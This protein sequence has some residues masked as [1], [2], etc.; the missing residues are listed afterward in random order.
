[1]IKDLNKAAGYK[2]YGAAQG[3]PEADVVQGD[4]GDEGVVIFDYD[5]GKNLTNSRGD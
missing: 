3:V 2:K 4:D 1:M 5:L